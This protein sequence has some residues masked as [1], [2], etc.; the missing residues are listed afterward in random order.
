[1]VSGGEGE[2]VGGGVT[3]RAE[4]DGQVVGMTGGGGREGQVG[5]ERV[6]GGDLRCWEGGSRGG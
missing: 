2:R 4:R 3:K 6:R 5:G 1:M